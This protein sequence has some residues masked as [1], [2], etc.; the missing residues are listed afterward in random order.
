MLDFQQ[1]QQHISCFFSVTNGHHHHRKRKWNQCND[2]HLIEKKILWD[3]S[4]HIFCLLG[5][6]VFKVWRVLPNIKIYIKSR[7]QRERLGRE[8]NPGAV[9]LYRFFCCC[10][11][12]SILWY[13]PVKKTYHNMQQE[14]TGKTAFLFPLLKN[15]IWILEM[16]F[17]CIIYCSPKTG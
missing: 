17:K 15:M 1:S 4:T 8:V 9:Q 16:S 10:Y 12:N 6:E 13:V 5:L 7:F 14:A 3:S 2:I 11:E